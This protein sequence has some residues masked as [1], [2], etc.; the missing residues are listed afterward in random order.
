MLHSM[1]SNIIQES[2]H[3]G[4]QLGWQLLLHRCLMATHKRM[5]GSRGIPCCRN[6]N[7]SG[8]RR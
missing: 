4:F 2:S 5:S 1:C 6:T 8:A 7:C 3:L